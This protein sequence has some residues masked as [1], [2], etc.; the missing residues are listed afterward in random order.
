VL[1]VNVAL[2]DAPVASCENGDQ[3]EDGRITVDE[4]LAAV[5]AALEGCASP[6]AGGR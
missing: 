2:E 5:H 4:A 3:N 6:Q 1:L